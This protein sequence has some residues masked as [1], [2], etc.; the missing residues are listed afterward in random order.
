MAYSSVVSSSALP[1]STSVPIVQSSSAAVSSSTSTQ[2]SS[3]TGPADMVAVKIRFRVDLP[4]GASSN[5]MI[6][7]LL[8][9]IT[10]TVARMYRVS[11]SS[12]RSYFELHFDD[13]STGRRL[14][15]QTQSLPATLTIYQSI[16]SVVPAS[17]SSVAQSVAG[18]IAAGSLEQSESNVIGMSVPIQTAVIEGATDSAESTSS[19]SSLSSGA[20]AGIVV[21]TIAG[22]AVICFVA[23]MCYYKQG[24]NKQPHPEGRND[25]EAS[26]VE[27]QEPSI[28]APEEPEIEMQ[29]V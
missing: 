8:N 11:A 4:T 15:Q 13:A 16:S 7:P 22:V 19:S 9:D 1:S 24:Q 12:I 20:I 26:E 18:S 23:F 10:S 17:A 28:V 3:S 6:V 25:S 5:N 27:H 14:F 21:G 29:D 2:S